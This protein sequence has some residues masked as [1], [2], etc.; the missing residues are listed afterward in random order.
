MV[1]PLCNDLNCFE[2]HLHDLF[3]H[4]SG[5]KLRYIKYSIKVYILVI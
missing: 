1:L 4:E 5:V 2:A 3:E